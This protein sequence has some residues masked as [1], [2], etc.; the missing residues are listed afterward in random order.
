MT[1][2]H[3]VK[4]LC[5]LE[6]VLLCDKNIYEDKYHSEFELLSRFLYSVLQGQPKHKKYLLNTSQEI[7]FPPI[8]THITTCVNKHPL[9]HFQ[10]QIADTVNVISIPWHGSFSSIFFFTTVYFSP[11]VLQCEMLWYNLKHP[12]RHTASENVFPQGAKIFP[13]LC[14]SFYLLLCLL[15]SHSSVPK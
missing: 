7:S 14:S 9:L 5:W 11:P 1:T 2:I 6:Y 4:K 3:Y 15:L 13:S 12:R 8:F 10:Y